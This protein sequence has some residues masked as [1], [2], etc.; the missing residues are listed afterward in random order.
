MMRM[1]GRK[2]VLGSLTIFLYLSLPAPAAATQ[3]H[4]GWEGLASHLF[5]HIIFFASLIYLCSRLY[6]GRASLHSGW[7][8]IFA[9]ACLFALWNVQTFYVHLYGECLTPQ[10]FT[11]LEHN[12]A[13]SF[14][15]R[16]LGDLLYYLGRF[17]HLLSLPA[18][19]CLLYGIYS[20]LHAEGEPS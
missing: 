13:V 15:V 8:W 4:G 16:S 1:L 7:R 2:N 14:Q 5:A 18:L 11:G 12:L 10:A 3:G 17:D 19:L 9:A 6:R 20:M